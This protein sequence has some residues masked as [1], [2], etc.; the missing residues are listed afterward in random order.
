MKKAI[1]IL[2][3]CMLVFSFAGMAMAQDAPN[4]GECSPA[5]KIDRG[6]EE[7]T[8]QT[9]CFTSPFDYEDF[10]MCTTGMESYCNP[11]VGKGNYHRAFIPVCDCI[12]NIAEFDEPTA[13]TVIDIGMEIMV[14]T[15][16]DGVPETGDNGVYFAEDVN[17]NG[18]GVQTLK[19]EDCTDDLG[20]APDYPESAF[21]G[22]FNYLL[23]NGDST[24]QAP[25]GG[26]NCVI[27]D[28]E[29]IVAF[30]PCGIDREFW[31]WDRALYDDA[32]YDA[33]AAPYGY[34]VTPEDVQDGRST[35]WVD[36]PQM[37]VDPTMADVKGWTVYV[38]VC[39]QEAEDTAE[40]GLCTD[41]PKC[42]FLVEIGTLGCEQDV[43]TC[44]D[45]LIYPYFGK[46]DSGSWWNG[47]SVTNLTDTDGT[48]NVTLYENDGEEF[49]KEVPVPANSTTVVDLAGLEGDGTVGDARGYVKVVTD[50]AASGFAM[51]AKEANGVSMG[52]L[53]QEAKCSD[54]VFSCD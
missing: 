7:G 50:F 40:G 51:M 25:Y 34:T 18:V 1:T 42:C 22:E 39:V 29:R 2:A 12:E 24:G 21:V 9:D 38:E 37:R 27:D 26:N 28:E 46:T 8:E 53:P 4:A 17:Q 45:T 36:I 19:G 13:G 31:E 6:L 16:G 48:A 3:A 30:E 15:N 52:Y 23:G 32:G 20:C 10:G 11:Q 43:K 35:W 49:T 14:D 41:C 54:C 44:S 5:G 33:A 47:M